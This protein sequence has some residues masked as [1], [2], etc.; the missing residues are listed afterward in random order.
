M[1]PPATAGGGRNPDVLRFDVDMQRPDAT[2][3]WKVAA[4]AARQHGV[5]SYTQLIELGFS[6][7]AI[8][9]QVGI[10][11]L[12]RV[13]RG[14]YAV[15]HAVLPRY[16]RTRAAVLAYEP[17]SL[18]SYR[19]A[20]ELWGLI[21]TSRF[22]VDITVVGRHGGA[23]RGVKVHFARS[24]H[25][26]DVAVKHGIPVTSVPR[27]LLDF[28]EVASR[29]ELER[30]WDTAERL[31]L[32]DLGALSRLLTRS[33]GRRGLKP[34]TELIAEARMPEPT[35]SELEDVL[36]DVCRTHG[37]P[38]PAFNT[39]VAGED[40]DAYWPHHGLVVELDGWEHHKTRA[41]R[42]RDLLKEERVK[43]AGYPFMRFSYRRLRDHPEQVA[44]VLSKCLG[45]AAILTR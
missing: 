28:A 19:S 45:T 21:R 25:R 31:E 6:A 22:V 33:S 11:R 34:L 39:S 2:R 27:T 1:E 5:V 26:E 13:F 24:V 35:R 38:I 10:G 7:G 16:G 8:A 30:A 17:Q 40:V 18:L 14:V 20:T 15:G 43:L 12:H 32:F 36:R 23:Q 44:A 29:R 4:L 3:P 42:E 9:Y 37:I 41:D